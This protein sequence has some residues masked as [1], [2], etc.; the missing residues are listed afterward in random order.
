MGLLWLFCIDGASDSVDVNAATASILVFL[1][2]LPAVNGLADWLSLSA[3]RWLFNRLAAG[4]LSQLHTGLYAVLDIWLAASFLVIVTLS[5]IGVVAAAERLH[6]AGGAPAVIDARAIL[7]SIRD[8]PGALRNWWAYLMIGTTLVP[9]L[10]HLFAMLVALVGMVPTADRKKLVALMELARDHSDYIGQAARE[11]TLFRLW[12]FL[13][14]L[15][16]IAILVVVPI[17][18]PAFG[19]DALAWSARLGGLLLDAAYWML[20]IFAV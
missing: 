2:L 19:A 12:P 3:S 5:S 20:D 15:A 16:L 8:A 11:Y 6:A 7:D 17:F 1:G 14:A 13:I 9:T 4:K 10:V 18:D